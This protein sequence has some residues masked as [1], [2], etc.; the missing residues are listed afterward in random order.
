[1]RLMMTVPMDASA[2][3]A[4][5]STRDLTER[6]FK[7]VEVFSFFSCFLWLMLFLMVH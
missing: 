3:A 7:K 6:L 1:V 5:P 4:V 2:T